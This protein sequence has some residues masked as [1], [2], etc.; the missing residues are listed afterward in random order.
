M[1]ISSIATT[2]NDYLKYCAPQVKC[3]P[4]AKY[5]SING[6]CNNLKIPTWGAAE[7]PFFRLLNAN[8]SDGNTLNHIV[9]ILNNIKVVQISI[10]IVLCI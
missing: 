5:R 8:F 1:H 6:S 9:Q 10:V 7:T 3:D 2:N 4:N